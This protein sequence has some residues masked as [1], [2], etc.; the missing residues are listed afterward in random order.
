MALLIM[1]SICNVFRGNLYFRDAHE[2]D[3]IDFCL[4]LFGASL[5]SVLAVAVFLLVAHRF[6]PGAF[7][8]FYSIAIVVVLS[9]SV[10]QAVR[11]INGPLVIRLVIAQIGGCFGLWALLRSRLVAD[12]TKH[13][14]WATV[15]FPLLCLLDL[16]LIAYSF[17]PND[18]NDAIK[19]TALFERKPPIVLVVFDEL[20][21]S[22]LLGDDG[23]VNRHRYPHLRRFSDKA[24]L[25]PNAGTIKDRTA[26]ALPAI[27][28]GRCR[29]SRRPPGRADVGV[30]SE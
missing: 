18:R 28:T 20:P 1:A 8:W 21:L 2:L 10:W 14:V 3:L 22:T 13:M 29:P 23:R 12:L 17:E 11:L 27:L 6:G 16:R 15:L 24:T 4:I 26:L 30:L 7:T 19:P 25:F 9:L 5:G